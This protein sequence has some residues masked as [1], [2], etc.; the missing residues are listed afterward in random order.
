M[1]PFTTR[2]VFVC[3]LPLPGVTKYPLYTKSHSFTRPTHTLVQQPSSEHITYAFP[4]FLEQ[5]GE[6]SNDT[7]QPRLCNP[8]LKDQASFSASYGSCDCIVRISQKSESE[9]RSVMSDSLRPHGLHSPWNSPGQ[10]T[11]VGTRSLLQGASQPK[12]QTQVSRIAGT[13]FL[14]ELPGKPKN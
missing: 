10:N 3:L 9:H 2:R 5:A 7:V 1:I 13:F 4:I 8:V 14:S 6:G 11:G 12:D